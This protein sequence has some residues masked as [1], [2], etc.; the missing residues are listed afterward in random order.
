MSCD[1]NG[2]CIPAADQPDSDF[3]QIAASM[4]MARQIGVYTDPNA[5]SIF[6]G[7]RSDC[8]KGKLGFKSCCS[9]K[10]GAANNSEIMGTVVSGASSIGKELA[11]IGS[12]YVYDSLMKSDTLQQGIGVM[13]S[14]ANNWF[15]PNGVS[16]GAEFF[17]GNFDPS[18]SYMGFTASFGAASSSAGS[19]LLGN[20]GSVHFSFNPYML[21]AQLVLDWVISCDPSD[22]MTAI[23]KGQNLCHYVGTFC[24]KK[25][26]G[27]CIE[28]KESHCCY[29]SRLARIVQQQGRAQ[30]GIEWGA[31]NSPQ[32]GGFTPEVF[33]QL[34]LAK[35]DLSEF[36]AEIQAKAV[37]TIPGT[38]RAVTNVTNKVNQ[39][40]GQPTG[41]PRTAPSGNLHTTP[42]GNALNRATTKQ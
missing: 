20:V 18:F 3:G 41:A 13:I 40:F 26:L 34:D 6:G 17:N 22:A 5:I 36:I 19:M 23:R 21:A 4:E 2:L 38:N 25:I 29:N 27:A 42:T 37:N 7:E 28:K 1:S 32:C 11:D 24:S 33:Q 10:A 35:M 14:T 30:L 8:S 31:A 15:T 9:P 16:E 39:Y 12:M